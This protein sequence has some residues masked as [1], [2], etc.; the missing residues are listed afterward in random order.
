MERK[1]H[2]KSI[3]EN[4]L[5]RTIAGIM[6][7]CLL[8]LIPD[9]IKGIDYG[10][11]LATV[12]TL[13]FP[14]WGYGLFTIC[15]IVLVFIYRKKRTPPLLS[16][17]KTSNTIGNFN[18]QWEWEKTE[19]NEYKICNLHPL[20]PTCG[21]VLT[22]E[23]YQGYYECINGHR[24]HASEIKFSQTYHYIVNIAK[25]RYPQYCGRIKDELL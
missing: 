10:S 25:S 20:C 6:T 16:F 12:L 8:S 2:F 11:T 22:T 17:V 13:R 18:W 1:I 9:S 3:I 14:L 19:A 5:I 23:L 4:A 24:V 15:I 7:M 21:N